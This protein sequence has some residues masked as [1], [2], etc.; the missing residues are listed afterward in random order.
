MHKAA[1]AQLQQTKDDLQRSEQA[2][3]HAEVS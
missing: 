1:V 3:I 2:R